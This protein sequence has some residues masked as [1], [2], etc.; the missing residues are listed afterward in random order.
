MLQLTFLEA[1]KHFLKIVYLIVLLIGWP[2]QNLSLPV[3]ANL[4]QINVTNF[5][6]IGFMML[7]Q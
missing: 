7:G 5:E 1:T 2:N 3:T 6:I 4:F